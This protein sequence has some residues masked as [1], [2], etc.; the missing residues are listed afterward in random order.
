MK[1]AAIALAI[2]AAFFIP[3]FSHAQTLVSANDQS[4]ASVSTGNVGF[5]SNFNEAFIMHFTPG[6]TYTNVDLVEAVMLQTGSNADSVRMRVYTGDVEGAGS[7]FATSEIADTSEMQISSVPTGCTNTSAGPPDETIDDECWSA[8]FYFT[9]GMTLNSGQLYTLVIERTGSLGSPA[10]QVLT[11]GNTPTEW[12]QSRNCSNSFATCLNTSGRGFARV[13][14][15]ALEPPWYVFATSTQIAPPYSPGVGVIEPDQNVTFTYDYFVNDLQT[16]PPIYA[17]FQVENQT[18][19]VSYNTTPGEQLVVSSGLSNFSQ[20]LT[21]PIGDAFRCRPY[22][23]YATS[24]YIFGY[25]LSFLVVEQKTSD[26]PF[27]PKP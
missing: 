22:L 1:K 11:N 27:T 25:W 26:T 19:G 20:D 2:L 13:F 18:T 7:L 16:P 17:G 8:H 24:T 12:G 9:G 14:A 23:S 4:D 10:Y 6:I 21:L 3:S 15:D 5:S